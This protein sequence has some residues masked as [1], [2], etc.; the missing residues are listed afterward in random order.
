MLSCAIHSSARKELSVSRF[1]DRWRNCT[2][3]GGLKFG[4]NVD[5]QFLALQG[6]L[7]LLLN[8]D[9]NIHCSSSYTVHHDGEAFIE[10]LM[11]LN[12][13]YCSNRQYAIIIIGISGEWREIFEILNNM[14]NNLESNHFEWPVTSPN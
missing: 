8:K 6:S 4:R 1:W 11:E 14:F 7:D 2:F 3:T 13:L 5:G 9:Y 10:H 12:S